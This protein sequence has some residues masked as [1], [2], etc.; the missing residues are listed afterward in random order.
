MANAFVKNLITY[1]LLLSIF[2]TGEGL[3]G[4]PFRFYWYYPI[5]LFFLVYCIV[6]YHRVDYR[7]IL[8]MLFLVVFS[9]V[10]YRSGF[11]L[12]VKQ[13]INVCMS[14]LVFSF[15]LIHENRD[16]EGLFRKY[17]KLARW[18][19]ILG[20]VQVLMFS[21]QLGHYF[22]MAFPFL[23]SYSVTS[24]LQSVTQEPSYIAFTFAPIVF[25]SLHNLFYGGGQFVSKRWGFI[26]II[27][28]LL[29]GSAIAYFGLMI[30]LI[31]IYFKYFTY[32]RLVFAG[33]AFA[34][35]LGIGV[36]LYSSLDNV[37]LRVD[38]TLRGLS[39]NFFEDQNYLYVNLSTFSFLTN[40]NVTKAAFI[41]HPIL[42]NGFGTYEILYDKYTPA[43]MKS[44]TFYF[45]N[46]E[47]GSAM[48]FRLLAETGIV[49]LF[50]F[51]YFAF[52]HKCHARMSMPPEA[53]QYWLINSGIFVV[54]LLA[55][56]RN[57]NYT[58]H[59]K[60]LFFLI[61]YY[62][63]S[64][65]RRVTRQSRETVTTVLVSPSNQL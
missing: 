34:A 6:I 45:M 8:T 9:L 50:I 47:D 51:I 22:M 49:G 11:S 37:K 54:V 20:F 30:M 56:L 14:L 12:V 61:L 42:G 28:Y 31:M 13:L 44:Y 25:V 36:L 7:V 23:Q 55:L 18:I 24:R 46:R 26:F 39:V 43:D 59:G 5:Y 4:G 63:W 57:G 19:A 1:L 29:T 58:I 53:L 21:F 65:Y 33:F 2:V 41:D 38:D 35:V 60:M 10:T 15:L 40:L 16:M 64:E 27:A 17:I 3:L 32:T 62:S 48:L 52:R